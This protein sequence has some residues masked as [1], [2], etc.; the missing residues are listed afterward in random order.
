MLSVT[1][2]LL[3]A[4]VDAKEI[5]ESD[6]THFLRGWGVLRVGDEQE[7]DRRLLP[8]PLQYSLRVHMCAYR[9]CLCVFAFFLQVCE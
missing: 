5:S 3:P 8:K 9:V 1:V 7:E 2:L 6:H 4:L